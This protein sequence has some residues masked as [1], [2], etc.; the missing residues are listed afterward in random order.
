MEDRSTEDSVAVDVIPNS[1]CVNCGGCGTTRMLVHQVPYFR[2]LIIASFQCEWS[3][4]DKRDERVDEDDDD[5][6]EEDEV[7]N[8][9][10]GCGYRNN[11]VTFGGRIQDSGCR[12]ELKVRDRRDLNRQVI[13]SE[14]ASLTI[15]E[16]DFEIP[17]G[18]LK[19]EISTVEGFISRAAKVP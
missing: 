10:F 11:E 16:V 6:D 12:Y 9:L 15:P 7:G 5:D 17:A 4:E 19:G 14:F 2:E 13:K 3:P 8:P 18:T 1:M